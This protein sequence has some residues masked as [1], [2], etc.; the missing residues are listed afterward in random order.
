MSSQNGSPLIKYSRL[1]DV[2][3]EWIRN[4]I[5]SSEFKPGERLSQEMITERLQVSRTPVRD[6]FNRLQTEGLLDVR[7][8]A[9]AIVTRLSNEKLAEFYELRA[10]LEGPAARYACENITDEDIAELTRINDQMQQHCDDL[11]EFIR[12]NRSFH[13]AL[14]SFSRREYLVSHIFQLWDL[15]E[16]YRYMYIHTKGKT[17]ASIQEHLKVLDALRKRDALTA[18]KV[19]VDHLALVVSTLSDPDR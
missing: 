7:P 6:A 12:D 11:P 14:Y 17:D 19:I 18:G 13:H 2:V 9:G 5:L 3:Y 8:N 1:S 15:V 16:P 10:L 4:A